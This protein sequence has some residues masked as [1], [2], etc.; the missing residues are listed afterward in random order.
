[1]KIRYFN[2]NQARQLITMYIYFL[3]FGYNVPIPFG[4][5]P[6]RLFLNKFNSR[7]LV[8][9]PML[10][11]MFPLKLLE[12]SDNISNFDNMQISFG[13]VPVSEFMS[14]YKYFKLWRF[15]IPVGMFPEN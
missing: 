9:R 4:I 14:K 15:P 11:G 10:S 2:R 5:D 3:Q 7:R 13:I 8:R 12:C 1:M 6:V